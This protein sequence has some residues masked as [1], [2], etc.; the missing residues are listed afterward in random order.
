MRNLLAIIII[1][2]AGL[3]SGIRA[4]EPTDSLWAQVR[5]PVAGLRAAPSHASE[6]LTQ[7][8]MGTPALV[9]ADTTAEW[10]TVR[11]PDGYEGFVNRTSITLLPHAD[12]EAWRGSDRVVVSSLPEVKVADADGEIVT[13]LVNGSVLLKSPVDSAGVVGVI[14]PDGREGFVADTL[15]ADFAA[16]VSR[17][18]D[19]TTFAQMIR[20][21]MGASY[22]WGGNTSKMMDCSGLVRIVFL[23]NGY[24]T[25]RDASM[26]WRTGQELPD[27]EPLM[28]G[29]LLFFS[30]TP[31]GGI[32]HVAVYSERESYLHSS[33]LVKE[34]EMLTDDP[35]FSHRVYRGA[36]RITDG[37]PA[38]GITPL[39]QHP[40][41]FA[42]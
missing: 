42:Q 22:L 19:K 3:A 12:M 17:P 38:E 4:A 2:L 26:L 32:N 21:L 28:E 36:R 11:L 27:G 25:P 1:A 23:A 10:L 30:S 7:A 24:L 41:Y 6:L 9:L 5:I 13:E 34:S 39:R 16:W 37:S 33:G 20:Q 15:V 40:W 29:D 31:D 8:I 14:L 35:D 18:L